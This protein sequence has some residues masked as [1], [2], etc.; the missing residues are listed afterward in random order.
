[1][2]YADSR[3]SDGFITRLYDKRRDGYQVS[4]LREFPEEVAGFYYYT[5]VEGDRLDLLASEF[6]ANSGM[7]WKIL[8]HN[9]EIIDGMNIPVGTV[10]R[11]PN[12]I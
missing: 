12:G 11:I 1:M 9:P 8:D 6:F 3:Y 2:I 10:L 5:W 4:V 7:W